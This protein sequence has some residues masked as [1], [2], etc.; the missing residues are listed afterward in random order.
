[1]M[2]V[3]F[4]NDSKIVQIRRKINAD[5]F[6]TKLIKTAMSG[7]NRAT[8]WCQRKWLTLYSYLWLYRCFERRLL[9]LALQLWTLRLQAVV[10][11]GKHRIAGWL[12]MMSRYFQA[13]K[14]CWPQNYDANVTPG[15]FAYQHAY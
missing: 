1:M 7:D 5:L 13:E 11:A 6:E 9:L 15:Y 12:Q 8:K 3:W 10:L 4:Q 2:G 14:R